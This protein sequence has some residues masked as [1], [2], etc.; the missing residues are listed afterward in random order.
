MKDQV[1]LQSDTGLTVSSTNKTD[2]HDFQ[3]YL[4]KVVIT[5][6][7]SPLNTGLLYLDTKQRKKENCIGI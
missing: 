3:E 5:T 7:I 4:L 2:Q 1:T 6:R